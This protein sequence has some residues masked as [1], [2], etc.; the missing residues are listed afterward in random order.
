[1]PPI[2]QLA[3]V[4]ALQQD[5]AARDQMMRAVPRE[6]GDPLVAG[7]NQIDGFKC[8]DPAGAFYVFPNVAEVCQ[9]LGI[10]SHGLAMYLLEGA[11]DQLGVACLGGECFGEAG[12]GFLRFSCAEPNDQLREAIDFVASAFRREDRVQHYLDAHP[13]YR[14]SARD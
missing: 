11:D 6:G 10:T 2:V 13:Q 5:A 9:R 3:G 14:S 12:D 8:L 4:A 1:M 7:S